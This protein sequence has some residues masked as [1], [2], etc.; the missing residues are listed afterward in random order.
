MLELFALLGAESSLVSG[1]AT[2]GASSRLAMQGGAVAAWLHG[3]LVV[4]TWPREADID[5]LLGHL[6]ALLGAVVCLVGR[7]CSTCMSA[8][9]LRVWTTSPSRRERSFGHAK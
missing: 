1:D 7:C 8:F 5:V 4:A 9:I 6:I 3:S 2:S